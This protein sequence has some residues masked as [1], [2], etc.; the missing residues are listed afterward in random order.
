M[1]R[2]LALARL[3]MTVATP[4]LSH[5]DL[6]ALVSKIVAD[7]RRE[8]NQLNCDIA[9]TSVEKGETQAIPISCEAPSKTS[10][11]TPFGIRRRER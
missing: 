10:S 6:S 2:L 3:D 5:T 9:F 4:D 7:E 1:G 8:A 11:G